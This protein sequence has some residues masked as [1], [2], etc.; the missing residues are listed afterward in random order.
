MRFKIWRTRTL[1]S[2]RNGCNCFVPK[3][4]TT[5]TGFGLDNHLTAPKHSWLRKINTM[6]LEQLRKCIR[7]GGTTDPI[8]KVIVNISSRHI[9]LINISEKQSLWELIPAD[10]E[11]YISLGSYFQTKDW[12]EEQEQPPSPRSGALRSLR[13]VRRDLLVEATLAPNAVQPLMILCF[14]NWEILIR[15]WF[16]VGI[17]GRAGR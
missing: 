4:A 2:T 17:I 3:P 5:R 16:S 11:K 14:K 13:A 6:P 7:Y 1:N 12:G 9:L 8:F 15:L 10:T